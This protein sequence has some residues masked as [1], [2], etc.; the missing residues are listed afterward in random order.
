M[1]S[2]RCPESA[3]AAER[4]MAVVVLPTPPF[5]FATTSTLGIL[6]FDQTWTSRREDD[7][8]AYRR[9]DE[10]INGRT[11][12]ETACRCRCLTCANDLP[13]RVSPRITGGPSLGCVSWMPITIRPLLWDL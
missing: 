8:Q 12:H 5:W 7:R 13:L 10:Q 6:A 3:S 1:S 9:A 4:L 11:S 2:T